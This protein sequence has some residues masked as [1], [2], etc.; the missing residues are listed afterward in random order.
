M[1]T[2]ATSVRDAIAAQELKDS[3]NLRHSIQT[4]SKISPGRAEALITAM[5]AR[6]NS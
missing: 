1:A 3:F 5:N 6:F 4:K 2:V